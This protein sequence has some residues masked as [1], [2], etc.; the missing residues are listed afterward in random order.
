[1]T[2]FGWDAS[3]YD[4]DRGPM[5]LQAARDDGI[6]FFSH[7]SSEGTSMRDGDF[8]AAMSRAVEA[9]IPYIGA[10]HVVR[11]S[12]SPQSQVDYFFDTLDS[13]FAGWRDHP[14]FFVQCD[15]E[16]WEYDN[17]PADKGEQWADLVESQAPRP[18]V[19][20]MYASKGQYGNELAGTSHPLWNANY[21]SNN[22]G[23]YL[24]L[25]ADRGADAGPGWSTY[26]GKMPE[27]WQ[28]GSRATIGGQHTCDANAFRGTEAEFAALIGASASILSSFTEDED[29]GII[30]EDSLGDGQLYICFGF[31]SYPINRDDL[32]HIQYVAGQGAYNLA[33]REPG[34]GNDSEWDETGWI[35]QGWQPGVFGPVSSAATLTDEQIS[36][37]AQQVAD[38]LVGEGAL[39]YN[40]VVG[41]TK[42]ALR[43][44]SGSTH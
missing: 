32:P 25:Y 38:Q 30:A 26:S 40:Q 36:D 10:Y 14:G 7:K 28:Y 22:T 15:L 43:E 2:I 35:R 8:G 29:M 3:H 13:R 31:R 34:T 37:I 23:H 1:M 21:G 39:T 44:G 24:G 6:V 20:L 11:S 16:R 33:I 42:Q 12:P 18:L 9:G 27:L 41:A 19:C 4:W 5:D 17:V